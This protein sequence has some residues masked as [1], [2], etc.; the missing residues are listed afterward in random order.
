MDPKLAKYLQPYD[1]KIA[2]IAQE[3]LDLI[4]GS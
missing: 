3:W 1:E 2:Q 4:Y